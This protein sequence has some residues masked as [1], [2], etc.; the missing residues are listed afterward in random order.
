VV[1]AVDRELQVTWMVCTLIAF[2]GVLVLRGRHEAAVAAS[3]CLVGHADA[4]LFPRKPSPVLLR[5]PLA[6]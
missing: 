3:I 1:G 2:G 6:A 4:K 5:L